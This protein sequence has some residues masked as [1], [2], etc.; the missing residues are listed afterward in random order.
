MAQELAHLDSLVAFFFV[1][2]V[3]STNPYRDSQEA[4]NEVVL[5][6]T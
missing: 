4:I 5:D 3:T 1:S 2:V 6:N